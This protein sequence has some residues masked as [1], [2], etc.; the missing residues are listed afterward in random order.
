MYHDRF[1]PCPLKFIFM[2]HPI[3]WHSWQRYWAIYSV[4]KK[5]KN[6]ITKE[7]IIMVSVMRRMAYREKDY[8]PCAKSGTCCLPSYRTVKGGDVR[9]EARTWPF[10]LQANSGLLAAWGSYTGGH[11]DASIAKREHKVGGSRN[12]RTRWYSHI[13]STVSNT[14][15]L[16]SSWRILPF[17]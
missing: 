4:V 3:I 9:S 14:R 15:V 8:M 1:L 10:A 16:F 11:R 12:Q 13:K 5:T 6:K 7:G 17:F 2:Y